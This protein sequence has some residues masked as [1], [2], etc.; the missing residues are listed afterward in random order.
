MRTLENKHVKLQKI[1]IGVAP[2]VKI[3]LPNMD[4]AVVDLV[5]WNKMQSNDTKRISRKT[6]FKIYRN[7]FA[8]LRSLLRLFEGQQT[9]AIQI[10]NKST[11]FICPSA[12][13]FQS[14]S[15][16]DCKA[17]KKNYKQK[18]WKLQ[19][20]NLEQTLG[21]NVTQDVTVKRLCFVLDTIRLKDEDFYK[22]LLPDPDELTIGVTIMPGVTMKSHILWFP[23]G[24][25][26]SATT[27]NPY[28]FFKHCKHSLSTVTFAFRVFQVTDGVLQWDVQA[29][30]PDQMTLDDLEMT[31]TIQD[32]PDGLD[33][34][35]GLLIGTSIW[36]KFEEGWF[37]GNVKNFISHSKR[38]GTRPY[39]YDVAFGDEGDLSILFD[40]SKYCVEGKTADAAPGSWFIVGTNIFSYF[41]AETNERELC[42]LF[43]KTFPS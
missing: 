33:I 18:K 23:Q 27:C 14:F 16:E 28:F 35:E 20:N 9:P 7:L 31:M 22:V 43:P 29:Q 5:F 2:Y 40:E 24:W 11:L 41:Y 25:I 17:Y 30:E 37:E 1:L 12:Y 6:G 32:A 13:L 42:V 34:D 8:D 15:L 4:S 19:P 36:F 10:G 3:Q 21:G 38:S 39:Q 26:S